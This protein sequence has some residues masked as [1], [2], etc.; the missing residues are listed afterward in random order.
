MAGALLLG[1]GGML[2]MPNSRSD[3]PTSRKERDSFAGDRKPGPN[4]PAPFDAKRAM[5]YLDDLCKI[6]PRI[7][8]T[9]GM[10]KQ[11]D[12]LKAHFEK[13]GGKVELQKF[14]AKQ[15]SQPR[16]VEMAN[17]I[18]TWHPDR[19]RRVILCCH[20]DSRPLADQEPDQRKWRDPFVGANDGTSGAAW[21]MELAHH[22]KALPVKVGVDFVFF[23][24]EEYI[25]DNRQGV[26]R[27]FF[28]S[29]HFADTW[30]KKK[31]PRYVAAVLLDLFAG[32]DARYPW[33]MNSVQHAGAVLG[34][35]WAV[36]DELG[37]KA[38]EKRYGPTVL[39]DHLALNRV[40]IPTID[41]IDFDYPHYHRLSD[42]PA[43]CSAESMEQVAKVL[44]VWL[45]RVK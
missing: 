24:G 28:G 3:P 36:A 15:G 1:L 12:L 7:S 17:L 21:L 41:I 4:Q 9:P 8:A 38:F 34:E 40:G 44:T 20:Y 22:I 6:G 2:L 33:E 10:Q 19:E 11:Q 43:N 42:V 37:V 23:D 27:Y 16:P 35:V 45:Q 30:V 32:K 25:F 29:D 26:D 14:T 31:Q 13:L 39:D 18:V 5:G